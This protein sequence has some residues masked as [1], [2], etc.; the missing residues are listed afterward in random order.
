MTSFKTPADLIVK[1]M[2]S[3]FSAS[4]IILFCTR[5][6][7]R[8]DARTY[9]TMMVAQTSIVSFVTLLHCFVGVFGC[10]KVLKK[11][12][13]RRSCYVKAH[14]LLLESSL[15]AATRDRLVPHCSNCDKH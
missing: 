10:M 6:S 13:H 7:T 14:I 1:R 11:K 9:Y 4:C 12:L 3:Y 15:N 5:T 8:V 2:T